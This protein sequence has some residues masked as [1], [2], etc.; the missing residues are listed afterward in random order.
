M[1]WSYKIGSIRGIPIMLHVTFLLIL[2][3]FIWI[4]AVQEF[5]IFGFFIGFGGMNIPTWLKYVF[6]AI[7]SLLFFSTVLFHELSHSL[8]AKSYGT[9]IR[10]ITLF[11]LGGVAQM[12]DMPRNPRM[13]AKMAAAGPA[14]SLGIGIL[15]YAIYYLFGPINP[16]G[17]GETITNAALIVVGIIAFYN[18]M[19]G[20]FNLI[21]AFPMDGGRILRAFLAMRMP[22]IEATKK[23]VAV[24]KSVLVA[25]GILG[26]FVNPL[27]LLIAIYL[28]FAASGEERAT[29]ISVTLEGVKVRDVMTRDP[30]VVHVPPDWTVN[31]LVDQM[32][33]TK[34][35]GYPVQESLT[36]PVQGV[37]TFADVRQIPASKRDST[38]VEE[39]MNQGIIS[40]RSDA[41]AF[42]ALKLMGSSNIGRLIVMDNGQM[43]GIVS[44]TDLMRAIQFRGA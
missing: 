42:D 6:S 24:G 38:K 8:V 34:H 32:F 3:V 31:Q 40:I 11:A 21:P 28:Y 35:M 25:M 27:L 2:L 26:L 1:K 15:A 5:E 13:E 16:T 33:R 10:G 43:L 23:A 41:D 12:E 7:A 44:R 4:F 17:S 30:N 36:S 22:Y 14:F 39:I 20:L 37:V 29:V 19:L 18:I 9:K